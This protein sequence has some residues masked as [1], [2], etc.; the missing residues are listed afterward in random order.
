MP[1]TTLR[2]SSAWASAA[3]APGVER[4]GS[5]NNRS[6]PMAAGPAL[7]M[8]RTRSAA[9][10]RGQGH[11]PRASSAASSIS[12]ITA[13]AEARLRGRIFW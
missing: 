12:T 3:S 8:A 4:S 5:T 1:S 10:V 13:G 7:A 6:T 11:W 9:T 2:P